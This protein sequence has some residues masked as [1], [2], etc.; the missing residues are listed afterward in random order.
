MDA[1]TVSSTRPLG[2]AVAAQPT[3]RRAR[4]R[5]LRRFFRRAE[6][7]TFQRCLAVHMYYAERTGTLLSR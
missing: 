1:Q 4:R 3:R 6:V 5:F 2:R 7:T